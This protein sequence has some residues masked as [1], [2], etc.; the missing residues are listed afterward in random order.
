MS[1]SN[2]KINSK[3]NIAL[4]VEDKYKGELITWTYFNRAVLSR[5]NI[6]STG[7]AADVLAGT[8]N[9]PVRK[10]LSSSL[11]GHQQLKEMMIN[12]EIDIIIFFCDPFETGNMYEEVKTLQAVAESCNIVIAF[13]RVTADFIINSSFMEREHQGYA[14][15]ES[16]YLRRR[17]HSNVNK[18][19]TK[20]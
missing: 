1:Y 14:E 5:H 9:A 13:N 19:I 6:I 7:F 15:D 2:R 20:F 4:V 3:K 18:L 12:C 16:G 11:G 8:I 10:L 17:D